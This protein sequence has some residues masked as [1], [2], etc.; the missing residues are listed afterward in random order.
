MIRKLF[1]NR[2][3][4]SQGPVFD[5]VEIKK[6]TY[7]LSFLIGYLSFYFVRTFVSF[8]FLSVFVF[9]I[10]TKHIHKL[11]L[12]SA[13]FILLTFIVGYTLGVVPC[14]TAI[15]KYGDI[16]LEDVQC[17]FKV[18]SEPEHRDRS[19]RFNAEF[20]EGDFS[21]EKCLVTIFETSDTNFGYNDIIDVNNLEIEGV[22]PY[23][24]NTH[25]INTSTA[26]KEKIYIKATGIAS[27]IKIVKDSS[28]GIL[29]IFSNIKNSLND[30]LRESL[31]KNQFDLVSGILTGYKDY[32]NDQFN[33]MLSN[34][35][36][37][38]VVVVSGMHFSIIIFVILA[39]LRLFYLSMPVAGTITLILSIFIAF[40]FGMSPS[41]LRA[42]IITD[43]LLLADIF[44]QDKNSATHFL[45]LTA[46]FMIIINPFI[47]YDIG[48]VLSFSSIIGIYIFTER[49]YIILKFIPGYLRSILATTIA[50][51]ITTLPLIAFYFNKMSLGFIFGNLIITP[52]VS[53]III[54]SLVSILMYI[55]WTSLGS[56][57]FS[58]LNMAL[59]MIFIP[60]NKISECGYLHFDVIR[61]STSIILIYFT[62]WGTLLNCN[63][64]KKT[65]NAIFSLSIVVFLLSLFVSSGYP[66]DNNLYYY[67]FGG[68]R[69]GK[70][71]A[72]KYGTT[73]VCDLSNSKD[74]YDI[75]TILKKKMRS[76]VDLYI[77]SNK[78]SLEAMYSLS[79]EINVKK[80][81]YPASFKDNIVLTEK[82]SNSS[83]EYISSDLAKEINLGPLLLTI[84]HD[85]DYNILDVTIKSR[86]Y[87][88][89]SKNYNSTPL[90]NAVNIFGT[91]KLE[92]YKR[93]NIPVPLNVGNGYEDKLYTGRVR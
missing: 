50:A 85:N 6:V 88:Y 76:E 66:F 69:S 33:E 63:K 54:Y 48:F 28:A 68:P 55:L 89:I 19:I 53:C 27:D 23:D 52:L 87:L 5:T 16:Y 8:I 24:I 38:H 86:D 39:F 17:L 60:L 3:L 15:K 37:S 18:I 7:L 12:L 14:K 41:V 83:R 93:N 21:G 82:I 71:I 91:K 67:A 26:F 81:V 35:G 46:D 34:T 62:G 56:S 77:I 57:M 80:V 42:L 40:F 84:G 92:Y 73:I 47:I 4:Q 20:T 22:V 9:T 45:I 44:W 29:G 61:P 58:L 25:L 43:I 65:R 30:I 70:I 64:W 10:S 74:F 1:L 49:I 75:K 90:N 36:I 31:G 11:K 78:A 13:L 59:E 79:D 32:N 72:D 2:T 51:N